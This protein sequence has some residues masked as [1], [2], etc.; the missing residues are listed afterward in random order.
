[1]EEGQVLVNKFDEEFPK[2]YFKKFL[3]Y[4]DIDEEEFHK[5]ID[6][7]RSPHLWGKDQYGN[8]K[9]RHN[10]NKTGLND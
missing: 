6:S 5:T 7:F 9:L 3:E 8:L 10:V 2:I 1:M 4:I